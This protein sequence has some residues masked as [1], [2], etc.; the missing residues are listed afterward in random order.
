MQNFAE[1]ILIMQVLTLLYQL[2]LFYGFLK[3]F[4]DIDIR[5][6]KL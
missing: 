1:L 5:F 3:L 4:I 6:T 2:H